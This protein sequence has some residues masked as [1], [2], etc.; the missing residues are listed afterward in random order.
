MIVRKICT[1]KGKVES[2]RSEIGNS[3]TLLNG[4]VVLHKDSK[5]PHSHYRNKAFTKQYQRVSN[6]YPMLSCDNR[7]LVIVPGE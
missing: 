4:H 2:C 7:S 6:A 1:V 3:T 5:S